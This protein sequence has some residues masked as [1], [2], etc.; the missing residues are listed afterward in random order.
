MSEQRKLQYR[1]E[2]ELT[3]DFLRR[4]LKASL[5][6]GPGRRILL[7]VCGILYAASLIMLIVLG[8]IHGD[9]SRAVFPLIIGIVAFGL[10]IFANH[11]QIRLSLRRWKEQNHEEVVRICGG[12][13][14]DGFVQRKLE[15]E[16]SIVLYFNDIKRL[17]ELDG[18]W[19]L[20]TKANL[21]AFYNAAALNETDR[22]SVLALLRK[23]NPNISIRLPR[24]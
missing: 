8:S 1:T 14:E 2:M 23:N 24:I 9:Y 13:S 12:F 18:V 15:Q 4:V 22:K 3:E 19:I 10:M 17:T 11:Q 7:I 6:D 16:D 5:H 21:L 20:R